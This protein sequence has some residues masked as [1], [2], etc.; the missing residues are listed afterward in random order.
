MNN[1]LLCDEVDSGRVRM[2]MSSQVCSGEQAK[3]IGRT[4]CCYVMNVVDSGRVGTNIRS[5]Y[6]KKQV[7]CE[8]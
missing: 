8:Q 6:T 2:N 5:G 1:L 4:I 7:G 3:Q